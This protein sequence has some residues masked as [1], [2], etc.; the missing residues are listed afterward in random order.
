V[1]VIYQNEWIQP[2]LSKIDKV[3]TD[4]LLFVYSPEDKRESVKKDTDRL[5]IAELISKGLSIGKEVELKDINTRLDRLKLSS[6]ERIMIIN[7]LSNPPK[8]PDMTK[9][10][11]IMNSLFPEITDSIKKSYANETDESEWTRRANEIL[12]N[13]NV[14][15]QVRRDI[16]QGAITY[17]M[18]T[19]T[20][21]RVALENWIQRGG[22]R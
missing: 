11:P 21:N 1:G 7:I 17:Y 2:I 9:L 10:A 8:E 3:D 18:I 15:D 22:L 20:N 5:Y 14:E 12:I 6:Y 13:K 4:N 19:E 16:I